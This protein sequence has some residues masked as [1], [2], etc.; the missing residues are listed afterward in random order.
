MFEKK[1][2]GRESTETIVGADVNLRGNL[3]SEG[4]V[5]IEGSLSGEI[6]TKGDIYIGKN[7]QVKATVSANNAIISGAVIGD[8][9]ARE[10]LE[11]TET[12]QVGGNVA[13]GVLSIKSGAI[14]NGKSL[15]EIEQVQEEKTEKKAPVKKKEEK[16]ITE[17]VEKKVK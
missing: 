9:N 10:R 7:A 3:K 17:E 12:G 6:K 13:C 11:I 14:F 16:I 1:E 8:I 5:R 4:N 15:M 2:D